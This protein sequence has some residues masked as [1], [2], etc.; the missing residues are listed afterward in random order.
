MDWTVPNDRYGPDTELDPEAADPVWYQ[1]AA[2]LTAR[3]VAGRYKRGRV[4]PSE[5]QVIGEFG[6]A[7]STVR[8][9]VKLLVE[10]GLVRTVHG[11]GSYVREDLDV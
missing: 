1:L 6:V 5:N 11:R 4:I 9:A 2:I 3:I 8:K 10:K 7:R